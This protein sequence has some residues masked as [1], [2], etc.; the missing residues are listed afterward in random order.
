MRAINVGIVNGIVLT[1][2]EQGPS[3]TGANPE[4]ERS[5]F[6]DVF[7]RR[8]GRWEAVNAQENAV[9]ARYSVKGLKRKK[10][11]AASLKAC[12]CCAAVAE[13]NR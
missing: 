13:L 6:T 5:I 4:V 9:K 8:N 7:V 12:H 10:G 1:T 11:I 2:D 3:R